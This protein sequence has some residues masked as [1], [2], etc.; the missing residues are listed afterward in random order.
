MFK[1]NIIKDTSNESVS[2]PSPVQSMISNL[3]LVPIDYE[4]G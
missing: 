4:S 1:E 2:Y 3:G